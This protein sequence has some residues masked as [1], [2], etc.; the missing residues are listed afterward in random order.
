MLYF[1]IKKNWAFTDPLL[2]WTRRH[3]LVSRLFRSWSL[4]DLYWKTHR[5]PYVLFHPSIVTLLSAVG[6]LTALFVVLSKHFLNFGD[7]SERGCS[8]ETKGILWAKAQEIKA[9]LAVYFV[10]S[11]QLTGLDACIRSVGGNYWNNPTANQLLRGHKRCGVP[12]SVSG[13]QYTS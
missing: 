8:A 4:E 3:R 1:L 7:I 5:S 13:R 2:S 12:C 10:L 11:V 9:F 6:L